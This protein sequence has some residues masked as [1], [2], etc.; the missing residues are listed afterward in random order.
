MRYASYFMLGIVVE[1]PCVAA[2]Q[3]RIGPRPAWVSEQPV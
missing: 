2:D 1:A 3:V